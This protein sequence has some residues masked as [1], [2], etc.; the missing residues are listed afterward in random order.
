M[1]CWIGHRLVGRHGRGV[2]WAV[3]QPLSSGAPPVRHRLHAKSIALP[4]PS[5]PHPPPPNRTPNPH[6]S[7]P[8]A[9]PSA[10]SSLWSWAAWWR[11]WWSGVGPAGSC[12][13]LPTQRPT[14]GASRWVPRGRWGGVGWGGVGWGGV[15]WGEVGGVPH[16]A[17]EWNHLGRDCLAL[18]TE[19]TAQQRLPYRLQ[20][21][22]QGLRG[23]LVGRVQYV[24]VGLTAEDV[25][26]E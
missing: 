8:A 10:T 16:Q 5:T 6:P 21:H 14:A 4:P 1:Q 11:R 13:T 20:I 3:E 9:G 18:N 26:V 2:G 12:G 17:R 19:N 25:G 23:P 24:G 7:L 15:G 22:H